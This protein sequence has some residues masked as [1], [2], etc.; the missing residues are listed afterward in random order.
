MKNIIYSEL[1][2]PLL[3]H[4]HGII[5]QSQKDFVKYMMPA[6]YLAPSCVS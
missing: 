5:H 4:S 6:F 2:Q 1:S 3:T